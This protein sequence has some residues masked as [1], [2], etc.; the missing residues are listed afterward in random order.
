MNSS[1]KKRKKIGLKTVGAALVNAIVTL[2]SLFCLFPVAWMLYSSVKDEASFKRNIVSLPTE[3]HFE[4][5]VSAVKTGRMDVAFV[6][7]VFVSVIAVLILIFI[8]F[9]AGVIFARYSF[10]GKALLYTMFLSGMLI[11][12]HSLLIPVFVEL[13]FFSLINNRLVLALIYVALGLPKAIFLVTTF[14]VTIPREIEEAVIIDGGNTHDIF[15]KVFL[16]ISK[17][18]L[19]TVTI[20][21]FLDAWNEFPFSLVLM[22]S[23]ELKTLPIALTYFT[24]QHSVQYTPMMAGLTIATLPI[25]VVYFI[26]HKKIMEGMVAGSVKG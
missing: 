21:S 6:N 20:L 12:V 26:F 5:Y 8:A 14:A 1:V 13:K 19:S 10:K 4:N 17:P 18:I 3:F 22:G 24:G 23:P 11:P 15:F 16:P 9:M 7:S 25:V 2:L